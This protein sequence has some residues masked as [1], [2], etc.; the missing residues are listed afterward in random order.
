MKS[1]WPK[2]EGSTKGDD[3]MPSRKWHEFK[4]RH[5]YEANRVLTRRSRGFLD[6]EITTLFYSALHLIDVQL[7]NVPLS[8]G[9]HPISH[10]ER[11]KEVGLNLDATTARDY[12]ALY[13]LSRKARYEESKIS[14]TEVRT[15]LEKYQGLVKRLGQ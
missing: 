2:L 11:R 6:W 8:G 10:G 13:L 9:L 7:A 14:Q 15:A 5:N 4:R 12:N 1:V 3:C